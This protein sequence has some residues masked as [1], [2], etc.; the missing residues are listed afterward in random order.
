MP[1]PSPGIYVLR[2]FPATVASP[3]TAEDL[4]ATHFPLPAVNGV[5][6]LQVATATAAGA[7]GPSPAMSPSD[8][9]AGSPAPP[10]A[11]PSEPQYSDWR[12]VCRLSF[13]GLRAGSIR[14]SVK[15]AS[16][17]VRG[18]G[19]AA[20]GA[21]GGKDASVGG[22]TGG[23][24]SRAFLSPDCSWAIDDQ[25]HCR[26]LIAMQLDR[27]D[28]TVATAA[29][30][31][32]RTGKGAAGSPTPPA[33][34]PPGATKAADLG[35]VVVTFEGTLVAGCAVGSVSLHTTVP[36]AAGSAASGAAA[37]SSPAPVSSW[38]MNDH[39]FLMKELLG[40]R[41][42]KCLEPLE[43]HPPYYPEPAPAT[44][45]LGAGGG[46][47]GGG[48]PSPSDMYCSV[49]CQEQ[50]HAMAVAK[51]QLPFLQR[52][53]GNAAK[54]VRCVATFAGA[55][56]AVWW[57]AV[58][59][60]AYTILADGGNPSGVAFEFRVDV[61]IDA[62]KGFHV[63]LC[64]AAEE[65]AAAGGS[66]GTTQRPPHLTEAQLIQLSHGVFAAVLQSAV[67]QGC[68]AL[69]AAVLNHLHVW[70]D[71]VEF[72]ERQFLYFYDLC[73]GGGWEGQRV[74][75][76]LCDYVML[77]RPLYEC[78]TVLV[79]AA[80]C[81]MT[82]HDYW[83]RLETAK[84]V[85]ISLYNFNGSVVFTASVQSLRQHIVPEQ[86]R[87][88]LMLLARVFIMMAVR[89]T[90]EHSVRMLRRAEECYKDALDEDRGKNNDKRLAASLIQLAALY[91]LFPDEA[92]RKKASEL[93][94]QGLKCL[95][96]VRQFAG[97]T[98]P[99]DPGVQVVQHLVLST[100]GASDPN[101]VGAAAT[102]G[103]LQ[104]A[105]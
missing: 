77:V 31:A 95:T 105:A 36:A 81:S 33:G 94:E 12:L 3:S 7:Q 53:L 89:T 79:E 44:E 78:A 20:N 93:R 56:F 37:A 23:G 34:A 27:I 87:Q 71:Y 52:Y 42:I 54:S 25:G 70:C 57:Q 17:R 30:A 32:A 15:V 68:V 61:L 1:R 14:G 98:E 64:H 26:V 80:L 91:L 49:T 47:V 62:R 85:L 63:T 103:A 73:I 10:T 74:V 86:Q 83:H 19:G 58:S 18:G 66:G 104:G 28:P 65:A 35:N 88:T 84:G 24:G 72:V 43:L 69:A 22:P 41:C 102:A 2:V 8:A 60:T 4:I 46:G 40:P 6:V 45:A 100:S 11:G 59:P 82:A 5:G 9:T 13:E 75:S 51:R 99:E 101:A 48:G 29:A 55:D 38:P 50:H 76:S 90:K 92:D 16:Q 67:T 21:G 97:G 96:Q 39:R